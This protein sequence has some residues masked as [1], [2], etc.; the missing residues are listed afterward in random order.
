[1][2]SD[3]VAGPIL[4]HAAAHGGEPRVHHHGIHRLQRGREGGRREG[5]GWGRRKANP[6][7]CTA[8]RH[9][10]RENARAA[11]MRMHKNPNTWNLACVCAC[12][13]GV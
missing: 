1:M 2:Q 6:S 8:C 9:S 12:A 7:G 13:C 3:I 11:I 4:I 10:A 5:G